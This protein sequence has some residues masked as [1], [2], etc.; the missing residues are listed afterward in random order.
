M[1]LPTSPE[2]ANTMRVGQISNPIV[3]LVICVALVLAVIAVLYQLPIADR[4][5]AAALNVFLLLVLVAAVQWGARYAVFLSFVAALGFSRLL[6]PQG[7]FHVTD[8]RVWT[9]LAACLVT[10]LAASRLSNGLRRAVVEADQRRAE[11]VTAQEA[12]Q[13]SEA[14]LTGEKRILEMVAKGDSLAQIL[15]TL[16]RLVEERASDVQSSILLVEGNCLWHGGAPSLPKAYIDAIDG[17]EIGPVVGSCGTAAYRGEQ[18]IVEDIA[19]DP[20]WAEYRE[21]AL[22][23]SLRACW[24]TPIF[25]SQGKV[26]ATFAMYYREP[27]RPSQRDREIIEQITHL[28]GVAIERKKT[29]EALRRSESYLAEAQRL[30]HTGSWAFSPNAR[31]LVYWSE[32][33]FRLWGFDP[34]Q[35][36]PDPQVALQR[37]H[38]EDRERVGGV[39]ERAY[40]GH[41]TDNVSWE[42]RIV[43]PDGTMKH[44]Q[45]I[46]HPIFDEAGQLVEYIG[47]AIDVTERKRADERL[48]ESEGRFRTIFENAGAGVALVDGHG[49]PLKCNPAF[50]KMLGFT[51]EELRGK[52]FT[53]FTHPDDIEADWKL[54]KEVADGKRDRYVIEKRYIKKDGQVM[55]GQLIV[56]RVESKDG[57]PTDYMVAM[58]E[59]ITERKRAEAE[60]EKLRQLEADLAHIQRVSMMGELAGSLGHEVK[61]PIAAAITNANTCRRWL[62]RDEPDLAE[63]REAVARMIK[64]A[65]RASDIITRTTSLYKKE[66]VHR[67]MVDVNEVIDEIIVLL[68]SQATRARI[69]VIKELA[70]D[71]P[72]VL[73]DRVQLQQVMMNL[74][75]NGIDA[76]SNIVQ[77]R[78]LTINTGLDGSGELQVRVSDTGVGLP[79]EVGQI[80]DAFFT[81]KPHG[82]GMGLAISRTIIE[83]HGGR[84]W[85]TPQSGRGAIF[86][87]TLPTAIG[88]Y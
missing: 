43:L 26:M 13:L 9:L 30:T 24:S 32:E 4:Y 53:E 84:L 1:G 17:I 6:P 58:V 52:M 81:T 25:S 63:A 55:W 75:M 51:E 74:M 61:Q 5:L 29:Q 18:V 12:L 82:T 69:S 59:D 31:K 14:T 65:M 21:A 11:A 36:P 67:E 64:D 3:R 47:T 7:H 8:T 35:G 78:E 45:G 16:C 2:R 56:S 87:F 28:A 77:A 10:G 19:I 62:E 66:A 50:T 38:P 44:L 57:E 76:M 54:Y 88:T 39:L 33:Q 80:F 49:R 73:G 86:S 72:Q 41:L 20:L 23:H 46:S 40:A 71:I 27:R 70:A 34:L 60:R 15:D 22:P 42:H 48:R 79:P 68:R 37:V 85:A 83:S